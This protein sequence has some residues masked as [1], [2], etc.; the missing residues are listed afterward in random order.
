MNVSRIGQYFSHRNS[1]HFAFLGTLSTSSLLIWGVLFFH[2]QQL[3]LFS[4]ALRLNFA[5]HSIFEHLPSAN[6]GNTHSLIQLQVANR[7]VISSLNVLNHGSIKQGI[8]PSPPK[9]K[10][11][12]HD[13]S[14]QW[15]SLSHTIGLILQNRVILQN[16]A[17]NQRNL[18]RLLIEA[19]DSS[20]LATDLLYKS[21]DDLQKVYDSAKQTNLLRSI[22]NYFFITQNQRFSSEPDNQQYSLLQLKEKIED[23]IILY[24]KNQNHLLDGNIRSKTSPIKNTRVR[25]VLAD[26]MDLL[27]DF[28]FGLEPL[29]KLT[30]NKND[31]V[32]SVND[33]INNNSAMQHQMSDLLLLY[34]KPENNY[35][36]KIWMLVLPLIMFYG[37]A[38]GIKTFTQLQ[39]KDTITSTNLV[40]QSKLSESKRHRAESTL[41]INQIRP[42]GEGILYSEASELNETTKDIANAYN[43]ARTELSLIHQNINSNIVLVTKQLVE[44]FLSLNPKYLAQITTANDIRKKLDTIRSNQDSRHLLSTNLPE[45]KT[46]L[47]SIRTRLRFALITLDKA[48]PDS[49]FTSI[50]PPNE[51]PLASDFFFSDL[52]DPLMTA[53][54]E[55]EKIFLLLND[56]A[57]YCDNCDIPAHTINGLLTDFQVLQE[58]QRQSL[59]TLQSCRNPLQ[60]LQKVMHTIQVQPPRRHKQ[61]KK[62][63]TQIDITELTQSSV[64]PTRWC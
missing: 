50:H 9:L 42:L 27:R 59:T 5:L 30:K 14:T 40:T 29:S 28:L 38:I 32:N 63:I 7:N 44:C 58:N 20:I 25:R 60:Q 13:I 51:D 8:H 22:E 34:Q 1:L 17:D 10:S 31:L 54:F 55:L 53:E 15:K 57:R 48:T 62:K 37:L 21:S 19:I 26:N 49:K 35:W 56:I 16:Y 64:L 47:V 52:K 18:H 33:I 43:I 4:H 3:D 11:D 61:T 6:K 23:T 2:Q 45:V 12:L 46:L 39:E 36:A 24:E 41:L